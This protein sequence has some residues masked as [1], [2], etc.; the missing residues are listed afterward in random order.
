MNKPAQIR[1]PG[2][3]CLRIAE[4]LAEQTATGIPLSELFVVVRE[5]EFELFHDPSRTCRGRV[6]EVPA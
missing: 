4:K 2:S 3:D 6:P 1:I 5:G